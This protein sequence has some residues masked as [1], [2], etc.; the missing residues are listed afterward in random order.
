MRIFVHISPLGSVMARSNV[1]IAAASVA[2]CASSAHRRSVPRTR[3]AYTVDIKSGNDDLSARFT[4]VSRLVQA[5]DRP[6]PGLAGLDAARRGRCGRVSGRSALR[7][8]LRRHGRHRRSTTAR[9]PIQGRDDGHGRA[10]AISSEPARSSTP[11]RRPPRHRRPAPISAS[12]KA[13]PHGRDRSS[14][15]TQSLLHK[16]QS[17]GR[18]DCRDRQARRRRR[19]SDEDDAADLPHRSRPPGAFRRR[20][21]QRRGG[22]QP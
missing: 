19:S 15:P 20:R 7:G 6:P 14:R 2:A 1:W 3:F 16:L 18:P 21:G 4:A 9:S 17:H 12:S 10:R 5:Q 22:H 11:R 8:L 13:G